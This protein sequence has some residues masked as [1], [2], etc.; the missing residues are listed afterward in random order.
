VSWDRQLQGGDALGLF[1]NIPMIKDEK[2]E[3]MESR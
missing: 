2:D 3:K 1:V